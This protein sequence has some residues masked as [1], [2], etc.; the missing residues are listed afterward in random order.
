MYAH[1]FDLIPTITVKVDASQLPTVLTAQTQC[2][3]GAVRAVR[4]NGESPE[5]RQVNNCS[6]RQLLRD[7]RR[8]Q[9]AEAVVADV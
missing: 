6:G 3:Q 1:Q 9:D 2:K 5:T 4:F 7:V 8:R